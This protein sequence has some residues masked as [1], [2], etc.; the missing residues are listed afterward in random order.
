MR[1]ATGL[2]AFVM[3]GS[4][5]AQASPTSSDEGTAPPAVIEQRPV[6]V[7]SSLRTAS[8]AA[9][10]VGLFAGAA[11]AVVALSAQGDRSDLS[12]RLVNGNLP[13]DDEE[14]LKLHRS[15]RD[16]G[17][18]T[19][20]LTVAS[21]LALGTGAFLF[22]ASTRGEPAAVTFAPAVSAGGFGVALAATF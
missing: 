21:A 3:A 7:G 11:A 12:A 19:T 1:I 15:L 8:F 16:R 10:G 4:A 6:A 17:D 13:P 22:F 14:A 9:F 2:V 5:W 18:L 20:G